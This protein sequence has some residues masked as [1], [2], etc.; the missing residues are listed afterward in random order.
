MVVFPNENAGLGADAGL[1][2]GVVKAGGVPNPNADA[3]GASSGLVVD[4][5]TFE[6]PLPP[7][8]LLVPNGEDDP[9]FEVVAPL[10]NPAN[11]DGAGVALDGEGLG[12]ASVGGAVVDVLGAAVPNAEV[13]EGAAKLKV[14]GALDEVALDGVALDGAV[15]VEVL[16]PT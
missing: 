9:G 7:K 14:G 8:T 5:K 12:A 10:A 13:D 11:A 3:F 4:P 2:A 15:G 16:L 6:A 1:A